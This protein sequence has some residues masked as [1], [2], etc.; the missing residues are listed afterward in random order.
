MLHLVL[1]Q[2][3]ITKREIF[4]LLQKKRDRLQCMNVVALKLYHAFQIQHV[5]N[6][7]KDTEN[8]T[9]LSDTTTVQQISKDRNLAFNS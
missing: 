8:W 9:P 5:L 2:A 4:Y 7:T 6:I 3:A 1:H